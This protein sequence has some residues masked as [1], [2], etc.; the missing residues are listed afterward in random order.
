MN[1]GATTAFLPN[2]TCFPS[3]RGLYSSTVQPGVRPCHGS[4]THAPVPAGAR[5]TGSARRPTGPSRRTQACTW[6]T[7][8]ERAGTRGG[9]TSARREFD[10]GGR[11]CRGA[12]LPRVSCLHRIRPRLRRM[13]RTTNCSR[14]TT[15]CCCTTTSCCR[16]TNGRPRT[17]SAGR[18]STRTSRCR[19]RRRPRRAPTSSGR[20]RGVCRCGCCHGGRFRRRNRP[21]GSC[22]IAAR[23]RCFS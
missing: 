19:R 1:C 7:R 13:T 12:R 17:R 10:P 23:G 21:Y 11:S 16:R 8:S 20:C 18:R 22:P 14:T 3:P 4:A 2:L 15:S 5:T 6:G 9:H